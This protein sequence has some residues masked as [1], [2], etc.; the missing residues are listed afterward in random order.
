MPSTIECTAHKISFKANDSGN[1][2]AEQ[3]GNMEMLIPACT[4]GWEERGSAASNDDQCFQASRE[5]DFHLMDFRRKEDA[6]AVRASIV[7]VAIPF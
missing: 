1:I 3:A 7:P 5:G 6:P 4:C 2:K